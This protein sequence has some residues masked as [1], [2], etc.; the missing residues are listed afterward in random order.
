LLSKPKAEFEPAQLDGIK[1]VYE[2]NTKPIRHYK[3][4]GE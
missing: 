1:G 3:P 2:Q 4:D